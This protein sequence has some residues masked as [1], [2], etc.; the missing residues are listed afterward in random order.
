MAC[1]WTGAGYRCRELTKGCLGRRTR[2]RLTRGLIHHAL[3]KVQPI[4]CDARID[5]HH[6][7][8]HPANQYR[9]I[10]FFVVV[11][12]G[13]N[14]QRI[15]NAVWNL[16]LACMDPV[17]CCIS[18]CR[19][20]PQLTIHCWLT[21]RST[22]YVNNRRPDAKSHLGTQ[23]AARSSLASQEITIMLYN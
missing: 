19:I 16:L 1:R 3:H 21:I 11:A 9:R 18:W 7:V 10:T 22:V 15:R 13:R 17:F 14:L 2:E 8:V 4:A 23:I 12:Y 6:Y 20:Q 5:V